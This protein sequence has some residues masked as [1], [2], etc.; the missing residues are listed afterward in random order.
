MTDKITAALQ[1]AL[2]ALEIGWSPTYTGNDAREIGER[3][4]AAAREALAAPQPAQEPVATLYVDG[5][6]VAKK[7]NAGRAFSEIRHA[8]D[9]YTSPQPQRQPL[10]PASPC[11]MTKAEFKLFRLGW[12]EC[13]AAHGITGETK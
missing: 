6:W 4:I 12:L 1:Q 10:P 5:Y 11:A 8:V 3:A 2:D 7:T 13:E 9:V